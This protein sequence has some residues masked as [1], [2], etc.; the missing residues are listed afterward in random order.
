M[1]SHW[2]GTY[3]FCTSIHNVY[4]HV[5]CERIIFRISENR[6]ILAGIRSYH[7]VSKEGQCDGLFKHTG[8]VNCLFFLLLLFPL[9][10]LLTAMVHLS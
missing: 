7:S 6:S 3:T 10:S 2:T 5:F 1:L 8:I 9:S 4:I